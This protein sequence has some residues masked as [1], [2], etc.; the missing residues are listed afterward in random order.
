MMLSQLQAMIAKLKEGK[1][2]PKSVTKEANKILESE[3][4][5][6]RCVGLTILFCAFAVIC[7]LLTRF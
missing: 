2:L 3:V 6:V 4:G 1:K 5:D 7:Q